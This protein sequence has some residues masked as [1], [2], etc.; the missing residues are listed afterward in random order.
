MLIVICF[1]QICSRCS[2]GLRVTRF[3]RFF[4]SFFFS[5]SSICEVH[6]VSLSALSRWLTILRKQVNATVIQWAPHRRCCQHYRTTVPS[7]ISVLKLNSMSVFPNMFSN[8]INVFP[9][10]VVSPRVI[11][12]VAGRWL[13]SDRFIRTSLI[14]FDFST[15]LG[16]LLNQATSTKVEPPCYPIA[17]SPDVIK[18]KDLTCFDMFWFIKGKCSPG[19]NSLVAVGYLSSTFATIQ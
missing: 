18:E 1:N 8:G 6:G 13:L 15:P 16:A 3:F 7:S 5:F 10:L 14:W 12:T 2:S 17:F 4:F 19:P 9:R 11:I